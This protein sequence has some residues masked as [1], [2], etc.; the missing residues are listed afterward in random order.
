MQTID[1]IAF[2]LIIWIG[3]VVMILLF[4]AGAKRLR[5]EDDE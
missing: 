1:W 4:L 5:G 2:G 3:A